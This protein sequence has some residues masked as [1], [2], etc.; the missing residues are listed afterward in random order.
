MPISN[1]QEKL[2]AH[3]EIETLLWERASSIHPS[4]AQ[5]YLTAVNTDGDTVTVD[6][7]YSDGDVGDSETFSCAN[8][9]ADDFMERI[10][11]VR[12]DRQRRD[13]EEKAAATQRAQAAKIEQDWK[14]FN[15]LKEQFEPT[16]EN[17]GMAQH[18]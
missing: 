11:A 8:F 3:K 4:R 2:A 13:A 14:L 17:H 12:A 6:Y 7:R 10:E 16:A 18:E 5:Q 1:L 15:K 9:F